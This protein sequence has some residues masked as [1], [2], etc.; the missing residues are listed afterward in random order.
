MKNKNTRMIISLMLNLVLVVVGI[1]IV[2]AV[3]TKAYSFGH[4]IFDEQAIN[5]VTEAREVEVTITD[6]ISARKL[7]ELL[8]DKGLV[9]DETI[10]F[11]QIQLSDYKDELKAGTYT[12]STAMTP[13]EMFEVMATAVEEQEE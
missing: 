2:F 10:T 6:G 3:G 9:K 12:L 11:F 8:Y 7:A 4:M 5:T 13:T 1:Y